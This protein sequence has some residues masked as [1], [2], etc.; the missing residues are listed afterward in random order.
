[1]WE[2]AVAA[3]RGLYFILARVANLH[4]SS[5][6]YIVV[7]VRRILSRIPWQWY[8][9]H[10]ARRVS[11]TYSHKYIHANTKCQI[12]ERVWTQNKQADAMHANPLDKSSFLWL[13]NGFYPLHKKK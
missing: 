6:I 10:G 11:N 13:I 8:I 5:C 9:F 4:A 7:V 1:V 12:C 3:D 2:V